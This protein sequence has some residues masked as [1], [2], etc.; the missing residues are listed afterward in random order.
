[1]RKIVVAVVV[2]AVVAAGLG[3]VVHRK[4]ELASLASPGAAPVPVRLV[5]VREGAVT[6]GVRTVALVQAD[7]ATTVAAQV[8]GTLVAVLRREGDRVAR[9]D[10]LARIDP[11]TL[12]DAAAA[13]R[14]RLAAATEELAHQQAVNRRDE[15]LFAGKAIS[16]QA[17]DTSRA[18]LEGAR[19]AEIGARRALETART[20][21]GYA[22]VVA[23]YAGVIT[24]RA[25]EPG[26]LATP[27]KPLF[28]LQASGKARLL[29]KLSQSS[30][31]GIAPGAAATFVSGGQSVAAR[32]TRVYPALDAARLG[33]VETVL[34]EAPF[35][36]RPGSIVAA[37]YDVRPVHG[38]VVPSLALLEG[39]DETMVVRARD[40]R[41]E[42]VPAS[43]VARGTNEVVVNGPLSPGDLVVTALPSELMALTAGTPLRATAA[44]LVREA[45]EV[46]P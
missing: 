23:P 1:M 44:P 5:A 24:G 18:Q 21:R 17:L 32:V 6:E 12:E 30:L 28:T 34:P 9:G 13:A 25:V 16:R 7:T 22:D 3:V 39:M 2:V 14:A 38:L 41:A 45:R 27:G 37:S 31:A 43:V 29:S 15:A 20:A 8:G 11:R 46:R 35:G 33:A 26:D 36:L 40:G 19:A 42:P 4:R 10:V